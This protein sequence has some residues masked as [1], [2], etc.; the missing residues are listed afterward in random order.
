MPIF[1]A[2][3]KCPAP[4]KVSGFVWQLLHGRI[5]TRNNLMTRRILDATGDV[6]CALCGE[7]METEFH[8]FLYCEIALLVWIEIFNW[9]DVPFGLPHNLFSLFH[10]LMEA[11]SYKM[12]RG[13]TMIASAVVWNL[14]KCR[15]SLLFDNGSGTIAEL[16]EAVK[17][18]SWKWWMSRASAAHCLLYEWRMEPRLCMLS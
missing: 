2:I 7:E 18:S 6:S 8:L 3:W 15:N 10:C 12:R 1:T 4:S 13:M 16:V 14:W 9:L 17:I 11:G 5:P